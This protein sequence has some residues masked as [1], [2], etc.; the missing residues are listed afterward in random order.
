MLIN[1]LLIG[2]FFRLLS[3]KEFL[4]ISKVILVPSFVIA[5]NH[6][7]H[8]KTPALIFSMKGVSK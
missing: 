1:L 7:I 2:L 3:L 4:V 6:T 5:K 8:Y